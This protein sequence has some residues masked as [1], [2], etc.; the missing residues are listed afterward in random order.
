MKRLFIF[1]SESTG[2]ELVLPVTPSGYELESERAIESLDMQETG[3][4]N[5]P[6]LP[7]LLD[8]PIECMFPAQPYPFCNAGAVTDPSYY[9][10]KFEGFVSAGEV[11]R[12][13]ISDTSINVPVLVASITY[14]EQD[15]TN[16]VYATIRLRGYRAVT[17]PEVERTDAAM[18]APR[19]AMELQTQRIYEVQKGDSFWSIC[20]HFYGDGSLGYKLAGYN[21]FSSADVLRVGQVLTIPPLSAVKAARAVAASE[22]RTEP[23]AVPDREPEPTSAAA[24]PQERAQI[25]VRVTAGAVMNIRLEEKDSKGRL[26]SQTFLTPKAVTGDTM[27]QASAFVN[28]GSTCSLTWE[29]Y[30]RDKGWRLDTINPHPT[31][32]E[33]LVNGIKKSNLTYT[34]FP[35]VPT[36]TKTVCF[37]FYCTKGGGT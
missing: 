36:S 9:I 12:F 34:P 32:V 5:L 1:K 29:L 37:V 28:V 3:R 33:M 31:G 19:A 2:E 20:K 21:G 27:R 6:G 4:L 23:D 11:L 26:L 13:V 17:A 22:P 8:K 14:G 15:G 24:Q 7:A 25:L 18:N 30:Y 35:F 10:R 16:D